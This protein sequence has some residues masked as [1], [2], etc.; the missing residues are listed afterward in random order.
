MKKISFSKKIKDHLT[1]LPIKKKCCKHAFND[2]CGIFSGM[3]TPYNIIKKGA[4]GLVCP[5]CASHFVRGLFVAAGNITDPVKSYHLEFSMPDTD[6]CDAVSEVLETCGFT[7]SRTFRKGRAILYFKNSTVIE[8]LLG[9]IG[10]AFGAFEVMNA[11][12]VK[13]LRKDTNRQVNCDSAN[14]AKS[15]GAMERHISVIN[16]LIDSG[17]FA[18]MSEELQTTA[19]LRLEFP[20]A[21][22]LELGNQFSPPI[23]KSGVKHRLDKIIDFYER[24]CAK[25]TGTES[26]EDT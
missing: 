25:T 23:S 21:T 24:R 10:A 15:V 13:E 18:A 6:S 9:F 5:E 26:T 14:I 20:N 4:A 1:E 2:G 3:D 8:D 22:M 11:K 12:I 16:K 7:A 19:M 17:D